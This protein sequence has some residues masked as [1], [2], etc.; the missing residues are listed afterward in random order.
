MPKCETFNKEF[1][2]RDKQNVENASNEVVFTKKSDEEILNSIKN[3]C[4]RFD[5]RFDV[6]AYVSRL[7]ESVRNNKYKN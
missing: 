5:P 1:L 4:I 6:N 3:G 7:E 2:K